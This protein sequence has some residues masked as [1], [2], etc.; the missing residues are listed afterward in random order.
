MVAA[1]M[2]RRGSRTRLVAIWVVLAA[3]L[4]VIVYAERADLV[5]LWSSADDGHGHNANGPRDLVS[6]PVG[7]L[8]AVEVVYQGT[9]HR[10]E[11]DA[12]KL[13]F[14][15]GVHAPQQGT[16]AHQTD[17]VAAERI[18]KTFAA[19]TRARIE[20]R[21]PMDFAALGRSQAERTLGGDDSVRDYGVTAPSML[22]LFY[23]PGQIEP[24]ARYAIG[25]VAPDTYSRYVQRLGSTEVVTIANYQIQNL[26]Q[27]IGAMAAAANA[28][29]AGVAAGAA[30]GAAP[31]KSN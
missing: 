29:A 15:H 10:F 3:L 23:L 19:F 14:Y 31:V 6:I 25:D 4:A 7:Q 17:P 12:Q 26:Q 5:G 22:V 24:S 13:W 21:F 16:H 8:G 18:E 2:S 1:T 9:M 28:P 20:R 27:L 11:R 30:A